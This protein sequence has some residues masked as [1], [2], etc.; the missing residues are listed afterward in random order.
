MRKDT[1]I[2]LAVATYADRTEAVRDF[3]RVMAEKTSGA[4]DHVAV[5]V[6]TKGVDGAVEVERHD[7]TAK[8]LAWGGALIGGA[9]FV[10]A[11]P[12]AASA[13]GV[14]GEYG[15]TRNVSGRIEYL[16]DF[17]PT[18][19]YVTGGDTYNVRLNAGTLRGALIVRFNP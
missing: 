15:F 11:P 7:S 2:T 18:K 6:M 5:A 3:D 13:I 12:I 4:F 16:Y 9:L 10:I 8:H 14:G 1:P 19:T 17:Y